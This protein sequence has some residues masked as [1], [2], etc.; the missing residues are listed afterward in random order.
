MAFKKFKDFLKGFLPASSK[1]TNMKLGQI[2]RAIN[3]LRDTINKNAAIDAA[4]W[5]NKI[6]DL[7]RD[8]FSSYKNSNEGKDLVV[9]GTGPTLNYYNPISSAYHIGV[10]GACKKEELKLDYY[11]M[12]DGRSIG[13]TLD[14]EDIKKMNCPKFFGIYLTRT[15]HKCEIPDAVADEIGAQ[16]YVFLYYRNTRDIP[17]DIE[18]FPVWDHNSI[19][20][21]AWYFA[22]FTNPRRIF[23]VGTDANVDKGAHFNDLVAVDVVKC[24]EIIESAKM[25][26]EH[27]EVFYPHIEFYSINPVGLKGIFNDVYTQSYLDANPEVKA[28]LG[29]DYVLLDDVIGV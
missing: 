5:S 21:H 24:N 16:R 2:D 17:L 25:L 28:T 8:T 1:T 11:F 4:C 13:N 3:R 15:I 19:I 18:Y 29:D 12:A 7:H 23:L 27:A 26:K 20:Q 6:R 9:I 10:N 22:L 14:L